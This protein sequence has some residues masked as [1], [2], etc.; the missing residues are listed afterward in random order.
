VGPHDL[1]LADVALLRAWAEDAFV[2]TDGTVL[3]F[4]DLA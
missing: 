4:C 1:S 3:H 2:C